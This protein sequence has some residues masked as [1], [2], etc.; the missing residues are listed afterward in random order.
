[1]K[2]MRRGKEAWA[3]NWMH[4]F[5]LDL[6]DDRRRHRYWKRQQRRQRRRNGQRDSRKKLAE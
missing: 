1:M 6:A 2:P 5:T 3:V 4:C